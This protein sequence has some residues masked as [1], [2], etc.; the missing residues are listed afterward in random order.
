MKLSH[1]NLIRTKNVKEG[2]TQREEYYLPQEKDGLCY[3]VN[4]SSMEIVIII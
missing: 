1:G 4:N 2:H 3:F